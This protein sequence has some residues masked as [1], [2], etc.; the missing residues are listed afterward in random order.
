M[1]F[2]VNGMPHYVPILAGIKPD[3]YWSGS[4]FNITGIIIY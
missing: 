4:G 2:I 3:K 1:P